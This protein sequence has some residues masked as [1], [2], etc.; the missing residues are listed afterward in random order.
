[1]VILLT[2]DDGYQSEGISVLEEVLA[3][4]GHEIWIC[5]PSSQRSATS[6]AMTLHGSVDIVSFKERGFHCSGTPADCVLYGLKSNRLGV[7]PDL[8]V[9]GIN[10]GYNVST[11]ILYSGTV[12]AA[13]EAALMGIPAIA[14]SAGS[15]HEEAFPFQEAAE[16]LANH[17]DCLL[18]VYQQNTVININVPPHPDG[19][20]EAGLIGHMVYADVL[21]AHQNDCREGQ[22][23]T[24]LTMK[25]SVQPQQKCATPDTDFL[26]VKKGRIS[27]SAL[28]VLP[29]IDIAAHAALKEL[30]NNQ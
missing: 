1:M 11:D 10:H 30:C 15:M 8:V 21:D 14:I 25:T 20:W 5:A 19:H 4:R 16:F 27:V 23:M 12:G 3:S 2:N 13:R 28:Q 18:S 9:S 24:T 17:L 22:S 26:V 29:A 7:T 6:Q